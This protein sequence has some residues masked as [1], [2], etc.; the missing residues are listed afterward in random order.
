MLLLATGCDAVFGLQPRDAAIIDAMLANHD[1]DGD[2]V[3]DA[4][5]NC[6][7]VA[8]DQL[9]RDGDGV[10]DWC[11]PHGDL[12]IDR[13]AYFDSF[14]RLDDWTPRAGTG[15]FTTTRSPS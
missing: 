2:H 6:P 3:D 15:L 14:Q 12:P 1:D 11:D 5:D 13:I 8:N 7:G 10:G 9:D 4:E